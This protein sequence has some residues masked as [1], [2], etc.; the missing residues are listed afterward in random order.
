[1][2]ASGCSVANVHYRSRENDL[3]STKRVF[4]TAIIVW[5]LEPT[6]FP[7]HACADHCQ[8]HAVERIERLGGKIDLYV[9]PAKQVSWSQSAKELSSS[10]PKTVT[11]FNTNLTDLELALVTEALVQIGNITR[12][13]LSYTKVKGETLGCLTSVTS[14]RELDLSSSPIT[15]DGLLQLARLCQLKSISL[16]NTS[17]PIDSFVYFKNELAPY[18]TTLQLSGVK[19]VDPCLQPVGAAQ[20]L[21]LIGHFSALEHLDLSQTLAVSGSS[22]DA[23]GVSKWYA[24]ARLHGLTELNLSNNN[25]DEAA[26]P[27]IACLTKLIVLNLAGNKNLTDDGLADLWP[28]KEEDGRHDALET[29]LNH[30]IKLNLS[31]TQLTDLGLSAIADWNAQLVELYIADTHTLVSPHSPDVLSKFTNLTTLNLSDTG[32]NDELFRGMW[33]DD[34]LVKLESL[35]ISGTAITDRGLIAEKP[36]LAVGFRRLKTLYSADTKVTTG[37]VNRRNALNAFLPPPPDLVLSSPQSIAP[38]APAKSIAPQPN[39]RSVAPRAAAKVVSPRQRFDMKRED[40][41]MRQ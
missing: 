11:F 24:L 14:L 41:R 34:K 5:S 21:R 30:L 29:G 39:E 6:L 1:V 4:A 8:D 32:V 17:L 12:L 15:G 36:R 27:A 26:V 25:L 19:V 40:I 23:D 28:P 37:G 35:D 33:T 3:M 31:G 20:F 18:L 9:N 2:A 16:N 7:A 10:D 38:Q 13:E 22:N